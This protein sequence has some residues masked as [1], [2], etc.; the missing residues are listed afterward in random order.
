MKT[1]LL[2][3]IKILLKTTKSLPIKKTINLI[4]KESCVQLK[5]YDPATAIFNKSTN[6]VSF[7]RIQWRDV[8]LF[9]NYLK[10]GRIVETNWYSAVRLCFAGRRIL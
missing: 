8:V 5:I 4:S 2:I 3:V 6:W 1:L 10:R 7:T 9:F